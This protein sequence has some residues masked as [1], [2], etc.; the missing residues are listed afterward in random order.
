MKIFEMCFGLIASHLAVQHWFTKPLCQ[1]GEEKKQQV[2]KP[3]KMTPDPYGR[4]IYKWTR[5]QLII[6]IIEYS[7]T[8]QSTSDVRK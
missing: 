6:I 1:F 2:N 5:F 3:K 7:K 8:N 4:D